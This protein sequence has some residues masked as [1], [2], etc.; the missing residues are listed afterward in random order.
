MRS[1]SLPGLKSGAVA[2]DPFRIKH[3]DRLSELRTQT[4]S[5]HT[6]SYTALAGLDVLD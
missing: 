1:P 2:G 4:R 6:L 3:A 5:P